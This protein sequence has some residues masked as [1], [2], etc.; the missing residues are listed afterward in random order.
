MYASD[1][2]YVLT[3]L[4][5]IPDENENFCFTFLSSLPVPLVF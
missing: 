4:D 3:Y 5:E 1:A 2:P